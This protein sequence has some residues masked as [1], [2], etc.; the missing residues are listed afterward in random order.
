M[1]SQT[2]YEL[3]TRSCSLM[4]RLDRVIAED[5]EALSLHA[6]SGK[7]GR[8]DVALIR[9]ESLGLVPFISVPGQPGGGPR[10]GAL[11]HMTHPSRGQHSRPN[12]QLANL[13][14]AAGFGIK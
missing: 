4:Q 10:L 6:L 3:P 2:G 1:S 9:E 12:G 11:L 7:T 8:R 5:N 13:P 14:G